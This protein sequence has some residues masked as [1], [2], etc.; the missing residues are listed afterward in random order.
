MSTSARSATRCALLTAAVLGVASLTG[1]SAAADS[2]EVEFSCQFWVGELEG[3]RDEGEGVTTASFDTAVP[4]GLVVDVGKRVTLDPLTGAITLPEAFVTMLRESGLTS[5][6]PGG[7][8]T[9][10]LVDSTDD[11]LFAFFDFGPTELPEEGALTLVV[12]GEADSFRPREPGVHS[13]LLTDFGLLIDTGGDDG[14]GA[15]MDCEADDDV[16]VD[17]FEAREPVTATPAPT[18]TVTTTPPVRPVVVQTDFAERD[19]AG[20]APALGAGALLTLAAGAL[21]VERARRGSTRRH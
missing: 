11:E 12:E 6:T 16:V 17:A 18:L 14:P 9:I 2:G 15:E 3:E 5:I 8:K 1:T 21:G 4:D 20:V 7:V 19:G 13:I 10:L